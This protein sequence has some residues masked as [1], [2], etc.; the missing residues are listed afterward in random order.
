MIPFLLLYLEHE[1]LQ[2]ANSVL[3]VGGGPTG[4]ELASEI[5]IDFPHKKVTLVHSGSR[6][7]EFI[8]PKAASKTL[9]WLRSKKVQ[10]KL[11]E[12][13]LLDDNPCVETKTYVTSL[14]ETIKADCLFVCTGK[15]PGSE[16]L[17]ESMLKDNIDGS[18]RLRVDEYLRVKGCK[19]NIFAV[20]DITDVKVISLT[21]FCSLICLLF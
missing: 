11:Q 7:L 21:L 6:L 18:G 13:V 12:S 5:A 10:V 19:N 4:V 15:P 17:K 9:E 3:I 2:S 1:E 14:G 8:G 20:G 16:W